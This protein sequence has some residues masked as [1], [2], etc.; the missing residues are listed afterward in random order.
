[1]EKDKVNP[2][3]RIFISG[4]MFGVAQYKKGGYH[5][6]PN[7]DNENGIHATFI[8]EMD[9]LMEALR[10]AIDKAGF[11]DPHTLPALEGRKMEWQEPIKTSRY[12]TRN[13]KVGDAREIP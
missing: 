5:E 1:M 8:V 6:P 4:A 9:E 3:L 12:V 11:I 2:L 7:D 10:E 13:P